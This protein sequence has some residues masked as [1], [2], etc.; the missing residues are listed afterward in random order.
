LVASLS[1][2]TGR[3]LS[4]SSCTPKFNSDQ[5]EGDIVLSQPGVLVLEG[6]HASEGIP[7]LVGCLQTDSTVEIDTKISDPFY[8]QNFKLEPNPERTVSNLRIVLTENFDIITNSLIKFYILACTPSLCAS[9]L[10][11]VRYPF[12]YFSPQFP[13][14]AQ[15]L[16]VDVTSCSTSTPCSIP[17]DNLRASDMDGDTLSF[18]ILRT[19]AH[20][21]L[22]NIPDPSTPDIEYFGGDLAGDTSVTLIVLAHDSGHLDVKTGMATLSL[23]LSTETEDPAVTTTTTTTTSPPDPGQED[24]TEAKQKL[25]F[26]LMIGLASGLGAVLLLLLLLLLC[27]CCCRKSGSSGISKTSQPS[28]KNAGIYTTGAVYKSYSDQNYVTLHEVQ[29]SESVSS[30]S[31][32]SSGSP[33]LSSATGRVRSRPKSSKRNLPQGGRD[34]NI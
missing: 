1:M 19:V 11:T 18:S 2:Q 6:E 30:T 5:Y 20:S 22:F 26:W 7:F 14:P 3:V 31:S 13:L 15:S 33:H 23:T 17:A 32:E 28:A 25:Y 34:S 27:F 12:N 21:E 29:S 4:Q 10:V 9:V 24:C 16:T 8:A